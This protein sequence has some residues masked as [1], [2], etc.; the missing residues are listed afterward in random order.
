LQLFDK[1]VKQIN[2]FL[3]ENN[4][5]NK[6]AYIKSILQSNSQ[7]QQSIDISNKRTYIKFILQLSLQQ[8]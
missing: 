2:A 6:R 1:K 8:Q 7:Q 5:S 4:S 3:K